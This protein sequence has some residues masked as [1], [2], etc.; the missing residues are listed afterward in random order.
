MDRAAAPRI[1]ITGWAIRRN[2]LPA[3]LFAYPP[4]GWQQ[5][6]QEPLTLRLRSQTDAILADASNGVLQCE[7]S[8]RRGIRRWRRRS[9][10]IAQAR[11]VSSVQSLCCARSQRDLKWVGNSRILRRAA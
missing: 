1:P 2:R 9:K 10:T 11:K 7:T 3:K 8:K 6:F 4:Q 5:R